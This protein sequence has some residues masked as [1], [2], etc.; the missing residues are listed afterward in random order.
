MAIALYKIQSFLKRG[1]RLRTACD[2]DYEEVTVKRP[3]TFKLPDLTTLTKALPTLVAAAKPA[4]ADPPVTTV[5][6]EAE[7][8]AKKK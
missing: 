5:N 6:Y 2:L 4:F 8:A 7:A 3:V 1:L